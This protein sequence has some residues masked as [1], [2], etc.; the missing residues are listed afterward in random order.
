MG[1]MCW[2]FWTIGRMWLNRTNEGET[3]AKNLET[4][5]RRNTITDFQSSQQLCNE[6]RETGI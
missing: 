6:M 3:K 4:F 1:A 2:S 5:D